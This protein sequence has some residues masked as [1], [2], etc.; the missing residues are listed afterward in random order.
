MGLLTYFCSAKNPDET[1]MDEALQNVVSSKIC[2][3]TRKKFSGRIPNFEALIV[4]VLSVFLW[5][6]IF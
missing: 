6:F 4:T 5:V 3:L 1:E 2:D